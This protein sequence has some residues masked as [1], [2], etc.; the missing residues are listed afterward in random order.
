MEET[1]YALKSK[2]E[3]V[4]DQVLGTALRLKQNVTYEKSAV[5]KVIMVVVLVLKK[6]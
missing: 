2:K 3:K 6:L 4:Q 5:V 1:D